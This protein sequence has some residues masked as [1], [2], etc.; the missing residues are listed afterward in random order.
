VR[1]PTKVGAAAAGNDDAEVSGGA[2]RKHASHC[3]AV[4]GQ[5]FGG[6]QAAET[7]TDEDGRRS[8]GSD[9]TPYRRAPVFE[10]GLA[11]RR[12]RDPG[13]VVT[14]VRF[15]I[16]LPVVGARTIDS[17][18][19]HEPHDCRRHTRARCGA[20]SRST[21]ATVPRSVPVTRRCH[22]VQVGRDAMKTATLPAA[23]T[24]RAFM[25]RLIA[26]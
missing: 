24:K 23:I 17:G 16:A 7:V 22:R 9:G 18:D 4:I 19:R 21:R 26:I 2:T 8:P 20:S 5:P 1:S 12:G 14:P 6:G 3:L 25:V 11:P 10:V 15:P 13:G